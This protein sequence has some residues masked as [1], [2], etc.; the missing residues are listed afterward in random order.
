MRIVAQT[1]WMDALLDLDEAEL[2]VVSPPECH[3]LV[4]SQVG[5]P[6]FGT[7]RARGQRYD[8]DSSLGS[9]SLDT[10]VAVTL[11]TKRRR[12]DE[13][14]AQGRLMATA[15]VLVAYACPTALVFLGQI[16]KF[17]GCYL[18]PAAFG[19]ATAIPVGG[20]PSPTW[21]VRHA[22]RGVAGRRG[23]PLGLES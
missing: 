9:G 19:A 7:K 8:K 20:Q 10:D 17:S 15:I 12:E 23:Q 22:L 18:V 16:R 13:P 5:S 14:P 11:D 3:A 6:F 2:V 4:A 1:P 21:S